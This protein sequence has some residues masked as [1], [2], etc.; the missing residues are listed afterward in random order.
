MVHISDKA[1]EILALCK[2]RDGLVDEALVI[3]QKIKDLIHQIAILSNDHKTT[4]EKMVAIDNTIE[5][6]TD[7]INLQ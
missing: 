1:T 3:N 2:E 6:I 4:L 5:T 7:R